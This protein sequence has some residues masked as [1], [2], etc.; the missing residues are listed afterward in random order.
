MKKDDRVYVLH[1]RDALRQIL[2]Y[3]KEGRDFFQRDKKTQDAIIRQF[4]VLGEA[5]KKL[6]TPFRK[7]YA[8]IPWKEMSGMRDKMIHEYFG[9]D[10][11]LVWDVVEKELPTL[12]KK[13]EKLLN[14]IKPSAG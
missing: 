1:V 10:L 7:S 11:D 12:Q 14:E 9:I 5:A 2:E 8:D 3:A 6:S 13:I 4:Q